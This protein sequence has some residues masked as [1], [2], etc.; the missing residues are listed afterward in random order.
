MTP[1]IRPDIDPAQAVA[2]LKAQGA[3][4]EAIHAYLTQR[5]GAP[6]SQGPAPLSAQERAARARQRQNISEQEQAQLDTPSEA[7][8]KNLW[9][10][11]ETT[12][13]GLPG[14][15]MAMAGLRALGPETMSEAMQ[16]VQQDVAEYSKEHPKSAFALQ[17]L[18]SAPT[19]GATKAAGQALQSVSKIPAVARNIPTLA[20]LIPGIGI[21]AG[22]GALY[23]A[24]DTAPLEGTTAGEKVASLAGHVGTGAA[25][26]AVGGVVPEALRFGPVR[27]IAG[28]VVGA[29]LAPKGYE[30]EGALAGATAGA[31]P[32]QTAR[33]A[34]KGL[35]ALADRVS[36]IPGLSEAASTLE[37]IGQATGKRGAINTAMQQM[38]DVLTPLQQ[39]VGSKSR[40]A[41]ETLNLANTFYGKSNQLFEK[42]KADPRMLTS[43][44]VRNLLADPDIAGAFKAT[45]AIRAA[46]GRPLPKMVT[47]QRM[48]PAPGGLVDATGKP[49]M[50]PQD[51][52]ES[53][54]D[55]EALHLVKR[56]VRDIVDGKESRNVPITLAEAKRIAPKLQS[57]TETLHTESPDFRR[58]DAFFEA[59]KTAEEAAALG[60]G[61]TKPGMQNPEAGALTTSTPAAVKEY[62][63]TRRTPRLQV[64]AQGAAQRGARGQLAQ[65]TATPELSEGVAGLVNQPTLAGSP[66][67][68][69]QRALALGAQAAP[70]ET[71]LANA[72]LQAEA[73]QPL[74]AQL[75]H[76]M[77][78][79][80]GMAA[81]AFAPPDV[82]QSKYAK[83]Y[84]ADILKNPE[85]Y[86]QTLAQSAEGR[87]TLSMLSQLFGA[88]LA[89]P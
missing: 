17:V 33:L 68:A 42:A 77:P 2:A 37:N 85:A 5:F 84:L 31:L 46:E 47:G 88:Q 89:R 27:A 63:V 56:I 1:P 44:P 72:R 43:A 58:A 9:Q 10:G 18:G 75:S 34:S 78:R 52:L 55:P 12:A 45:E 14:G 35:N 59:G 6:M 81:R 64:I 54:P 40:T 60:Y 15:K 62:V 65:A 73:A 39:M 20:K 76:L 80:A 7:V 4:D 32:S 16:N 79:R 86:Q 87:R 53:V 36:N 83:T 22:T 3:P 24:L 74:L 67:A 21:G 70:Y 23:S 30:G 51:V 19:W 82:L 25:L 41:D 29:S 26:G 8:A 28:G 69:E 66:A 48:V 61:A 13:S 38:Q 50:V 57:L 71:T 49:M 11:L